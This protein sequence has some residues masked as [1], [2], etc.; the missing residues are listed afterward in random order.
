MRIDGSQLAMAGHSRSATALQRQDRLIRPD[1]I[2]AAPRPP[3][4]RAADP[5][6]DAGSRLMDQLAR[7]ARTQAARS[8]ETAAAALPAA[9]TPAAAP[10][11][12]GE[13]DG[14]D[15]KQRQI[16]T[17][18]EKMFG[19]KGLSSVTIEQAAT[20]QA[21]SMSYAASETSVSGPGAAL[22]ER[23]ETLVQSEYAGFAARGTVTTADGR[24]LAFDLMYEQQRTV[25]VS[26]T[27][28]V[29]AG[30]LQDPLMI[31]LGGGAPALGPGRMAID[32]D[33][34][35]C[36][37]APAAPAPG[38]W[39]LAQDRDGDRRVG[40][41][42]ELFGPRSGDGFAEL[43]ALDQD[44]NGW[45]DEADA[46]WSMLGLWDGAGTW[47]TLRELGVGALATARAALDIGAEAD[48][49]LAGKVRAG[50]LALA[51]DGRPLAMQQIDLLV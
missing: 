20:V 19:V 30:A 45:I 50:G 16:L 24:T 22:W 11:A 6:P 1:G 10:S 9:A 3:G 8:R 48:G 33:G 21:S 39:I 36:T 37:D 42:D 25:A 27:T 13:A 35:G 26:S 4:G 12:A 14:L 46:A 38:T 5:G 47:K 23:T 2:P 43:G 34:D 29:M 44:G 51:E 7:A 41:R 28:R 17:I 32:L 18:L 31:A 49:A 15:A 40:G